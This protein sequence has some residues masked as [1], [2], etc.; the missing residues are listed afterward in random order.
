MTCTCSEQFRELNRQALPMVHE[1]GCPSGT[2]AQPMCKRCLRTA[3]YPQRKSWG[4]STKTAYCYSCEESERKRDQLAYTLENG[5]D[6]FIKEA[7]ENDWGE[8]LAALINAKVHF[9]TA[10]ERRKHAAFK[11]RP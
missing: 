8:I 5:L 7:N 9:I 11:A 3:I 1:T 2:P 6:E 4:E 10:K